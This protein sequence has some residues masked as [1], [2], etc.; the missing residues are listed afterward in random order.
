MVIL[1]FSSFPCVVVTSHKRVFNVWTKHSWFWNH[2]NFCHWLLR[3][4][5]MAS[6]WTV[7]FMVP[8][9]W[10][11]CR[12]VYLADSSGGWKVQTVWYQ[13]PSKSSL[14][15]SQCGREAEREGHTRRVK[16][17][18]GND[19]NLLCW[20]LTDLLSTNSFPRVVNHG[21]ITSHQLPL[22]FLKAPLLP[23]TATLGTKLPAQKHSEDKPHL[24]PSI[25]LVN[26]RT[27]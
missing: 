7:I 18:G 16:Q 4:L 9:G 8:W 19:N 5:S 11:T 26:L 20:E 10:T 22:Y 21:L 17:V 23:N 27:E 24:N 13:C 2:F 1:L 6:A 12:E 15:S 3:Q 25:C 14:T